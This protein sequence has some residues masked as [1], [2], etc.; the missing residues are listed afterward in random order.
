M[1][2]LLEHVKMMIAYINAAQLEDHT[3]MLDA[4][5]M[6]TVQQNLIVTTLVFQMLLKDIWIMLTNSISLGVHLVTLMTVPRKQCCIIIRFTTLSLDGVKCTKPKCYMSSI[7][8]TGAGLS[9]AFELPDE[10][11]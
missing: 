4:I 7:F 2:M 6:A 11:R 3:Q 1:L 10:F 9:G 8:S 5:A